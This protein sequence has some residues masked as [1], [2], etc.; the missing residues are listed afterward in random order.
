MSG[1]E[2]TQDEKCG[3]CTHTYGEHGWPRKGICAGA[4]CTPTDFDDD[5]NVIIETCICQC[6]G[7]EPILEAERGVDPRYEAALVEWQK[8]G[9]AAH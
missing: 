9:D 2:F 6:D 5:G 1:I 3:T 4:G 7:F 8:G